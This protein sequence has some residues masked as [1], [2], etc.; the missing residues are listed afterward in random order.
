V[1]IRTKASIVLAKGDVGGPGLSLYKSHPNTL[2]DPNSKLCKPVRGRGQAC[3]EKDPLQKASK[4]RARGQVCTQEA[5]TLD[6]S[7]M[8]YISGMYSRTSSLG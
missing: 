2:A 4:I 3:A 1:S 5:H 7:K 6:E 8:F